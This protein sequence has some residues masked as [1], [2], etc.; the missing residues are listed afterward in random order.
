M[1]WFISRQYQMAGILTRASY[2]RKLTDNIKIINY[3]DW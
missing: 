2:A 1:F 3:S